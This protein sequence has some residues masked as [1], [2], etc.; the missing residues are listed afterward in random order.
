[1]G[2]AAEGGWPMSRNS[3]STLP[4]L[5]AD[6]ASRHGESMALAWNETTLS[7]AELLR[8]SERVAAGLAE[9][10]V[11]PGTRF[12]VLL[13][14]WPEVFPLVFGATRLGATVVALNT[15]ATAAELAFYLDHA[16][17]THLAY[18]PRF[19]RHDYEARLDAVL[20]ETPAVGRR[21]QARI[22]VLHEG[23]LPPGATAYSTLGK[24]AA[25]PPPDVSRADDPAMVFFTSGSTARPK[26][27]VHGHRALAHQGYTLPVRFGMDA[28]DRVFGAL[29]M[30]FTG[31]FV[32]MALT[33]FATG[34]GLVLQD[35]F[36]AGAAL[37]LME[38]HGI[39][40]YAGWQL[41]QALVDHPGFSERRLSLS[42]G[43]W[44]DVAAAPLLLAADHH[45]VAVYGMSETATCISQADFR[46]PP[47]LRMRGFGRPAPGVEIDLVEPGT[48]RQVPRGET[49]EIRVRGPSL[50]LGYLGVP[51]EETFDADGYFRTGDYGRFDQDGTLLFDG[52][53][54]EVIKTAGVNVAAAEV[55]ACLAA[56]EGVRFAFVV[57]VPHAVRGEN[58]AAFVVPEPGQ[59]LDPNALLAH[60]RSEL[61]TYKIPRH[62]F[63]LEEAEIPRTGTHK[64]DKPALRVL[65]ATNAGSAF[66]LIET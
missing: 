13:P 41:A 51:P 14:N 11:G 43:I 22:A 63:R 61:A 31:G 49:G 9:L 37:D 35:H 33:A 12:G 2:A 44:S 36:E 5:L 46:D 18:S 42:K 59:Q 23:M 7:Y 39:T 28:D 58:V 24:N 45:T 60:C 47:D 57:P 56:A 27:V 1:M 16:E 32:I 3:V 55:E 54:K 21:L 38:R 62:L 52:R 53:L 64:V 66:D 30:F 50:M 19:L 20:G 25:A 8:E 34:A 10:G 17:V 40:V 65:A 29:P 15:M 6:T 4:G 48:N 26:G